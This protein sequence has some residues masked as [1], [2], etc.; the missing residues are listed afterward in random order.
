MGY[1]VFLF[2][3]LLPDFITAHFGSRNK[4]GIFQEKLCIFGTCDP[5]MF[6]LMLRLSYADT[7]IQ[8]AVCIWL[9]KGGFLDKSHSFRQNGK[10]KKVSFKNAAECDGVSVSDKPSSHAG[11]YNVGRLTPTYSLDTKG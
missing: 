5:E 4:L 8:E 11:S 3:I 10:S 7:D 9:E 2:L 6:D 1:G